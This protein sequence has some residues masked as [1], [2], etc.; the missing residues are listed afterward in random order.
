MIET[1]IAEIY[2]TEDSSYFLD[3]LKRPNKQNYILDMG[4][5]EITEASKAIIKHCSWPIISRNLASVI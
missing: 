4:A 5:Q 2:K 3:N 1:E